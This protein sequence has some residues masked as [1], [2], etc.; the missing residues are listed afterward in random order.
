MLLY[1]VFSAH[2]PTSARPADSQ[3]SKYTD[4]PSLLKLHLKLPANVCCE[5]QSN[6]VSHIEH[7]ENV[8]WLY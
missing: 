3:C 2:P 6:K 7:K 5:R 8:L 4:G 1:Y